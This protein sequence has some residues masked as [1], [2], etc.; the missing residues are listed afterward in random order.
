MSRR[1]ITLGQDQDT[2][3]WVTLSAEERAQHVY[4]PGNTGAGK[5]TLL[6]NIGKADIQNGDG[7]CFLDLHGGAVEELLRHVAPERADD[8]ILWDPLDVE[9]PFG[10][11]LFE[12]RDPDN[13]AIVDRQSDVFYKALERVF[14]ESFS[15]A[16]RMSDLLRNLGIVFIENQGFTLAESW[17][18]LTDRHCR[19]SLL[20]RVNNPQVV[21]FWAEFGRKSPRIQEEV[22]SS[23]LNKLDRFLTNTLLR[24]IFGQAKSSINF[25]RLMDE[26]GVLLIKLPVGLLGEEN[27]EFLGSIIVGKL[28]DAAFSRADDPHRTYPPFHLI[29]DEYQRFVPSAFSVLQGEG[30][31]FGIDCIMAHQFRDQLDRLNQGSTLN[32]ANKVIF[33]VT[34]PDAAVL[35]REFDCTPPLPIVSGERAIMTFAPKPLEHLRRSGHSNPLAVKVF[36][37]VDGFL[38]Q[39]Q[40]F[41]ERRHCAFQMWALP[42]QI[43][44]SQV[45]E[46]VDRCLYRLM[47][48]EGPTTED[49]HQII[50]DCVDQVYANY[51]DDELDRREGLSGGSGAVLEAAGFKK[52]SLWVNLDSLG[53]LLRE[54]PC[55][56]PSGQ[57]EPVYERA[58]LYS[59][60]QAER[61]NEL[62]LLPNFHA[63]CKLVRGRGLQ[64][65]S[66][67][68]LPAPDYLPHQG[69]AMAE[70]IRERS[71]RLYGRSR[72][73]VE[74][75]IRLRLAGLQ[76]GE[77]P[78]YY[79]HEH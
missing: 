1:D 50:D 48:G 60:V 20:A 67:R 43:K 42:P 5:T 47:T 71:R 52:N 37:R 10:V 69:R 13:P 4:V 39:L 22:A 31:K 29:A 74:E 26:S 8:V 18:F 12:C 34:A 72:A 33:R 11:N 58:R 64:E 73:E 78:T 41:Y 61:A 14:P 63:K 23:S 59:D 62:T 56:V 54:K 21:D 32:V 7:L 36:E 79:D 35:A 76:A 19:A 17:R 28:L 46:G 24:N 66:I 40:R 57:S 65:Y 30:R 68:T 53:A 51:R 70:Y 49:R 77:E 6:T 45:V 3:Q 38:S 2:G 55:M 75:A 25:R 16:P 9:R 44:M 15:V 27:A